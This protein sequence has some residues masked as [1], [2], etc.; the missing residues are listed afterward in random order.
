M[1][2]V[3]RLKLIPLI[4]L[5]LLVT[6]LGVPGAAA[7]QGVTSPTTD[8]STG[9]RLI[10]TT[11]ASITEDPRA[12]KLSILTLNLQGTDPT[13][14]PWRE[15]YARVGI[16][17]RAAGI[18]PDILVLQEVP[19]SK[20]WF[21]GGCDPK[22]YEAPFTLMNSIRLD[23]DVQYR[24]ANLSVGPP[25][26][27]WNP[28]H[29]G[30]AVLYNPARLRNVT[31]TWGA[32][33]VQWFDS[34]LPINSRLR[35]SYPCIAPPEEWRSFCQ[36][37]VDRWG[38]NPNN[39]GLHWVADRATFTRLEL[40]GSS[41]WRGTVDIYNIHAS[42]PRVTY[43]ALVHELHAFIEVNYPPAGAHLI[44]PVI[45]GDFNEGI[46]DMT[47]D[48]QEPWGVF[49]RFEIAAYTSVQDEDVIGVLVG[50]SASYS[51]WYDPVVVDSRV[52]PV[53]QR[54]E[55]SPTCRDPAIAWSDH[56]A[57]YVDFLLS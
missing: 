55:A 48:T 34:P 6:A 28:L 19:G 30:R 38:G 32:T 40:G 49:N 7:G 45:A 33:S 21:L 18:T 41:Y 51:A 52:L 27:G 11:K 20:C 14:G 13:T 50:E 36:S 17:M 39:W 56:C 3:K 54:P 43:S 42:P 4:I 22:D 24:I 47:R 29:Q 25:V 15:R 2:Q 35:Q 10:T 8:L 53:G 23:T 5:S 9:Q 44:P 46:Q 31:P 16:W 37:Y 26:E 57:V 12:G 1:T